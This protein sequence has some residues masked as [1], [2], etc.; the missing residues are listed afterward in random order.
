MLLGEILGDFLRQEGGQHRGA[1]PDDQ[2]RGVGAVHDVAIVDP[3]L[4]FLPD[5]LEDALGA[6]AFDLHADAGIG[7]LE[8]LG[9]LLGHRQVDR[10]VPGKLALLLGSADQGRR[11]LLRLGGGTHLDGVRRGGH[12]R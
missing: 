3:A 4:I 8:G 7:R 5:A 6:R 11:D 9:D 10:G 2:V 12:R 1:L